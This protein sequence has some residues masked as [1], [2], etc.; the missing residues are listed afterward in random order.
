MEVETGLK[1]VYGN[2]G[3]RVQERKDASAAP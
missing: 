3:S 2:G 1:G